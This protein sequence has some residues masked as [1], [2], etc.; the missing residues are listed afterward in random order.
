MFSS[1]VSEYRAINGLGNNIDNPSWGTTNEPYQ[2]GAPVPSFFRFDFQSRLIDWLLFF[3]TVFVKQGYVDG[4]SAP[5]RTKFNPRNISNIMFSRPKSEYTL[6]NLTSPC[7]LSPFPYLALNTR[8]LVD[9]HTS[10]GQLL[11]VDMVDSARG[12]EAMPILIN[13][14]DK[15]FNT[16]GAPNVAMLFSRR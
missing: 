3:Q 6:F 13:F 14:V 9:V 11:A 7:V 2:R 12:S 1:S 5:P 16:N 4:I 15:W 8:L 10:Y